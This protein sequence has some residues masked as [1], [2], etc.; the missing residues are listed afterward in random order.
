M[1]KAILLLRLSND[2]IMV[3]E[4]LNGY[5]EAKREKFRFKLVQS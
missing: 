4:N 1:G 2:K 5:K 3:Y